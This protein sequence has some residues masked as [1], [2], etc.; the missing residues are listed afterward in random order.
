M[1]KIVFFTFLFA[2]TIAAAQNIQD[3]FYGFKLDNALEDKTLSQTME[4]KY[5]IRMSFYSEYPIS[6]G[7]TNTFNFGGVKWDIANFVMF[8]PMKKFYAIE[9]Y[10]NDNQPNLVKDSFESLLE[11]L[12]KKYGQPIEKG[13]DTYQ[14]EGKNN[15]NVMLAIEEMEGASTV[16]IGLIGRVETGNKNKRLYLTYWSVNTEKR[17]RQF[18]ADQL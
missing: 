11:S 2:S 17:L 10:L 16:S 14:W 3:T 9:L 13:Q 1:R 6:V 18:E 15:V 8:M 12:T 7:A 4:S 5:S